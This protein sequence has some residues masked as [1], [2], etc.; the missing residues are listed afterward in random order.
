MAPRLITST[1]LERL[2]ASIDINE[3]ITVNQT[4]VYAVIIDNGLTIDYKNFSETIEEAQEYIDKFNKEDDRFN[5]D[6]IRLKKIESD[7]LCCINHKGDVYFAYDYSNTI[8]PFTTGDR[9]SFVQWTPHPL[10]KIKNPS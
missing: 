10:L 2:K 7:T 3:T 4:P 9:M 5:T 1:V 6:N 8:K